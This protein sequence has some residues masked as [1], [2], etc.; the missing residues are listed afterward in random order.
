MTLR[1]VP[2]VS[3]KLSSSNSAPW[4]CERRQMATH[5]KRSRPDADSHVLIDV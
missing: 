5:A 4:S 3:E 1:V 2:S